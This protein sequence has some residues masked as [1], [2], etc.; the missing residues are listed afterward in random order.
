MVNVT[1]RHG[2]VKMGGNIRL[3]MTHRPTIEWIASKLGRPVECHGA[4]HRT[5]KWKP[6]WR[7]SI[8]NVAGMIS[9]IEQILPFLI[10]KKEVASV[11]LEFCYLRQGSKGKDNRQGYGEYGETE[12]ALRDRVWA[13]NGRGYEYAVESEVSN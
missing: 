12:F 2:A 13:L 5:K 9:L 1:Q 4:G 11:L 8:G 7:V 6:C 3:A 10:T